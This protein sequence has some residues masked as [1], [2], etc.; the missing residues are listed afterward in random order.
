MPERGINKKI[1][2]LGDL[3]DFIWNSFNDQAGY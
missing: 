1:K 3:R 2:T